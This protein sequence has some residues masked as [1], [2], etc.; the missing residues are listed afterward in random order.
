MAV[1]TG[2]TPDTNV[3]PAPSAPSQAHAFQQPPFQQTQ[4]TQQAQPGMEK[5]WSFRNDRALSPLGNGLGTED[6]SKMKE[7]LADLVKGSHEDLKLELLDFNRSTYTDLDYSVFVIAGY[8]AKQPNLGIAYHTIIM[9]ST[10]EKLVPIMGNV[11]GQ[12]IEIMRAPE[13][14]FNDILANIILSEMRKRFWGQYPNVSFFATDGVV[15]GRTFTVSND[16]H[17][18]RLA[19]NVALAVGTELSMHQ[20]DFTDINLFKLDNDSNLVIN[21]AFQ[22]AP[23]EDDAGQVIRSDIMIGFSSNSTSNNNRQMMNT[24]NRS[25]NISEVNAYMDLLWAPPEYSVPYGAY[26]QPY[27]NNNPFQQPNPMMQGQ[28]YVG[29]LVITN[30][31]S[32]FG[33]TP[34]SILLALY[35]AMSMQEN[36]N[37]VQYYRP[38]PSKGLDLKDV[39]ALGIEANFENNSSG[40]G[41]RIDTK[42]ESF[43]LNMLGLLITN[44]IRPQLVISIDVPRCGASTWYE[45]VFVAAANGKQGAIDSIVAT[46]DDLTNGLFSKRYNPS[47]PMFVD[48]GNQVHLGYYNDSAG[49]RRDIRDID[50]LAVAN[51]VG[52]TSPNLIRD[53][54]DTFVQ[55]QY[56]MDQRLDARKKMIMSF[57]RESA[58]FTG[59]ADRVTFSGEFLTTLSRCIQESNMRV[60]INTPLSGDLFNNARAAANFITTGMIQPGGSMFNI[61]TGFAGYN[62]QGSGM[63]SRWY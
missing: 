35:T 2:E 43:T 26:Q 33:Y 40:F 46:A 12:P 11:N 1:N 15:V 24:P 29:R 32:N 47:M 37:W 54:S 8:L 44:L 14:A 38:S 41:T 27:Q 57:T 50:Y 21:I 49:Q 60:Q 7:K 55:G 31:V 5:R 22:S 3:P 63:Y 36:S 19:R 25:M 51:L 20:P 53:W 56:P 30:V 61:N 9:E 45:S 42:S 4:Q 10:G 59:F 6:F 48:V 13:E 23:V 34:G 52:E 16:T 28:K 18:Y 62:S 17:V 58:E 39:G